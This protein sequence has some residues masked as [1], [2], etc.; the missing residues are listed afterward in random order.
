MNV[1]TSDDC[2]G[3]LT[4]HPS[5]NQFVVIGYK[6]GA[7]SAIPKDLFR[8]ARD[9]AVEV[10]SLQIGRCSM[11]G[12]GSIVKCGEG[13]QR[14]VIGKHVAGGLRLRFL[15][16]D[17]QSTHTLC[18]VPFG[19]PGFRID[20]A[21]APNY[22]D[23]VIHHDVSIGDEAMLLGGSV[24]KSGCV[25]G[26]RSV[27]PPHFLGEPYGI[28]EGSPARLTG[29]RFSERVREKLLQLAWWDMPLDWLKQHR[30]AFLIDLA[31]DE[32]RALDVLAELQ[33]AKDDAMRAAH[34][35]ASPLAEA[36]Q[37][38]SNA[39]EV[40]YAAPAAQLDD[41]GTAD[42]ASADA[43]TADQAE[44]LVSEFIA[45]LNALSTLGQ[46]QQAEAVARQMTAIFPTLGFGWKAL[47]EALQQQGLVDQALAPLQRASELSPRDH[48]AASP[49][50]PHPEAT[51]TPAP[52]P[53]ASETV[54]APRARKQAAAAPQMTE[55]KRLAALFNSG[56]MAE[57]AAFAQSVANRYPRHPLGWKML[58]LA[59][60]A[61]GQAG[62]ATDRLRK[63]IELAPEDHEVMLVLAE[64]L[65]EQGRVA[66]AE[67]AYR[68]LIA[69]KPEHALAHNML[70]Q[71]LYWQF[72]LGEAE[73]VFRRTLEF[74]PGNAKTLNDL[75]LMLQLQ[76]RLAEAVDTFHRALAIDPDYDT[77]RSNLLFCLSHSEDVDPDDLAKQHRAFGERLERKLPAQHKRH[78]NSQD[79]Q[80]TLRV[81]FVS[82]DLFEHAV[83]SFLEPLL[84]DLARDP[85]LALYAYYNHS[86]VDDV[87]VRLRSHFHNWASVY[88]MSDTALADQIRADGI[89]ILIDLSG[90]TGRNRLQTFAR[91]PAPIQVSWLG[92]PATTGMR[93]M[94]YF[95]GDRFLVPP[96]E[97]ENQ[98]VEKMVYLPAPAPFAPAEVAP[99]TNRL[100]AL[101]NGYITFGSFNRMNKLRPEVIKLWAQVL[102]AV[103]TARMLIAGVAEDGYN[104]LVD[105]FE[106]EGIDR[107][108]LESRPRLQM[109]GYLQHH[110]AVDI[111]LDAFPYAGATTTLHAAWMG[112]P[113]LTLP[114]RSAAS[115]GGAV[116]MSHLAL[117]GFIA[118]DPTDF[119]EKAVDWAN[120]LSTL[121]ELRA[122][123]RERCAHSAY[124]LP[125]V[126]AEGMSRA[127]RLM[128][129]R[130]TEGKPPVAFDSSLPLG[131]EVL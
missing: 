61:Q 31:A 18:A 32:G 128:W 103:P 112:V 34:A 91:K 14:L 122:R 83:A 54:V 87:S 43:L 11:L 81:G 79:P 92:Y 121:A 101:A 21:P 44:A 57:A 75:G 48:A 82:G 7:V 84:V 114:G 98:F 106:Q 93:T 10:D 47:G 117:E 118:S 124:F 73:A 19:P 88:R 25:I 5:S 102:H 52:A 42:P 72:R 16:S 70:G 49:E 50:A 129:Q 35:T 30:K 76:G 77:A 66:E 67:Q 15:L 100:P 109:R 111:C 4:N 27:V 36:P 105:W 8:N 13:A 28:Y 68:R 90:H 3:V 60:R 40:R 1:K 74:A 17:P 80:R 56:R 126:I 95:F 24:I 107:T 59:L 33:Q 119:V 55:T 96:G 26:A 113:T 39:G 85:G 38:D 37:P 22:P 6:D 131:Q 89:D 94:D 9:E 29:F 116:T 46:H 41:P 20:D 86:I 127:L 45:T 99:P 78:T 71:T 23:T 53:D 104:K 120:N 69:L 110:H 97:A 125:G 130:W 58:G 64:L 123:M 63:A 108:R 62:E 115:R 12:A 2:I 51:P 65:K